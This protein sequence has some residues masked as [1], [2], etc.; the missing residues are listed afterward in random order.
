MTTGEAALWVALIGFGA[1]VLTI[2]ANIWN[3]WYTNRNLQQMERDR[4]ARDEKLRAKEAEN[5]YREFVSHRWWEKKEE[6]YH[7]IIETL[8][9][10]L[11]YPMEVESELIG[12]KQ[13]SEERWH[14]LRE[15]LHQ[16]EQKLELIQNKRPVQ[17]ERLA[18]A[19]FGR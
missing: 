12:E 11:H 1:S 3:N 6:A 8:W 13:L 17:P 15:H 4:W 16:S 7:Q 9:H 18:S 2:F 5:R 10:T 14:E 19:R